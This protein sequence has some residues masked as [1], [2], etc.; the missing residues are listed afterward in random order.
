MSIRIGRLMFPTPDELPVEIVERKG[1]GH[2]DT[3]VD[4]ICEAASREY[5]K[6][7]QEKFGIILH[8]NLDKGLLVGGHAH[9][10]FGKEG[11]LS[12]KIEIIIAGRAVKRIKLPSGEV[13]EIDVDKIALDAARE[14]LSTH[15][16]HLDLEKHV[17]LKTHIN[18]GSADLVGLFNAKDNVPLCNDTSFG[19]GFAPYTTLERLVYEIEKELNS[20]EFKRKNPAV[21]EDIK[22]M[23]TRDGDKYAITIAAAIVG[24]HVKNPQEYK[25]VKEIIREHAINV[26]KKYNIEPE[27]FVNTGD[28]PEKGIFYITV[29]GLSAEAGDDGQVG[30]GNRNTG[31]IT[32]YRPMSL[33]ATAGKNPVSHV[34]KLYNIAATEIADKIVKKV[35][36]VKGAY[37]YLL[38]R[39]GHP[40]NQPWV[41]NVLLKSEGDITSAMQKEVRA[42][43]EEVL[44]HYQDITNKLLQGK[45]QLF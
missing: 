32:P 45:I 21:G 44:E 6:Y 13:A 15:Y 28:K 40:I 33:E 20:E 42:V 23:G 37:V 38:G 18:E 29:T 41:A 5:S 12:K 34:G 17:E 16:R 39:I 30:R 24:R 35:A 7:T 43:A 1:L 4:S 9:P 11:Y 31:L 25:E 8:H 10:E 36:G 3:I 27:I 19:V 26:A 14:F 22:V 2:P